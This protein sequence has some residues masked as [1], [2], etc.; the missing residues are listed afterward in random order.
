MEE[1]IL[2]FFNS[3]KK[4]CWIGI[5]PPYDMQAIDIY[6]STNCRL[7]ASLHQQFDVVWLY[8]QLLDD[9][10]ALSWKIVMDETIRLIKN[11]GWMIVRT[12]ISGVVTP[13]HIKGYLGRHIGVNVFLEQ[14]KKDDTTEI[15]CMIFKVERKEIEKYC[16]CNWT[17]GILTTGKKKENVVKF[18]KSIRTQEIHKSEIIIAG[19]YDELYD[20]YNVKYL[21]CSM[22]RE[23]LAEISRKKNAIADMAMNANLM[24]VHDRFSLGD[25][26]FIGF[27]KYGYDFDFLTVTQM[28]ESGEEFPSIAV[29]IMNENYGVQVITQKWDSLCD[30][31][32]ING[33]LMIFKTHILRQIRFND[34]LCWEQKEDVELSNRFIANNIIPRINFLSSA[35]VLEARDGYQFAF[36]RENDLSKEM[37]SALFFSSMERNIYRTWEEFIE[38]FKDEEIYIFGAGV[39]TKK[40]L[41]VLEKDKISL[42]KG[43]VVS[44][45]SENSQEMYGISVKDFS[46]CL[47]NEKKIVI[48][49]FYTKQENT[50]NSLILK[51][52]DSQRIITMNKEI[53]NALYYLYNKKINEEKDLFD[54]RGER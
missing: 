40:I 36:L 25:D 17:F 45:V 18:L 10:G 26:F 4:N 38:L 8:E 20:K 35:N 23:E 53:N 5:Q 51:G 9:Y 1:R 43:I 16:D 19:P 39:V 21:D 28:S 15:C 33:G 42:I 47:K 24:I 37:R 11:S 7:S 49:L 50:K 32:Y 13:M 12:R 52:I 6:S 22:F 34:M 46:E 14:E 41:K 3:D 2:E 29:H 31:T 30:G 54:N 48:G 44:N 27:E